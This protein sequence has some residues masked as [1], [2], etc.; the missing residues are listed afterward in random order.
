MTQ[1]P[2]T[3]AVRRQR[4]APEVAALDV[5]DVVVQRHTLVE[6][7]VVCREDL[8]HAAVLTHDAINEEFRFTQHALP[9]RL[10]E[11]ECIGIARPH[12]RFE[13]PQL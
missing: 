13:V 12:D 9:Q 2:A 5:R 3:R 1:Q 6:E 10:V 4:D 11:R 8:N 7:R